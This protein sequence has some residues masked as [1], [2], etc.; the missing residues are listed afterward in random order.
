MRN[1]KVAVIMSLYRSDDP[2]MLKIAIDSILN[3]TFK[4]DLLVYQD[5]EVSKKLA[6]TIQY[7]VENNNLTLFINSI[8]KGLAVGLNCLINH[9][10]EQEYEYIARMDSDDIS[11]PE[12][13]KKQVNFLKLNTEVDVLGTSCQEFSSPFALSEKHLPKTHDE[14]LDFSITRC[15]FIH[16]TVMFRADVFKAGYRYP[17]DV[18]L[19]ED[20]AFWFLLLN[21]NIRFANM[22]EILLDYRLNETTIIRRKGLNKSINEVKLRTRNMISLKKITAKNVFLITARIGFHL[23]PSY[24]VKLAYKKIR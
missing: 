18:I 14:L 6:E 10:I 3:Q 8:N 21:N 13:I 16:P 1:S 15:P 7:Y 9:A 12:R 4:C 23:L 11:R 20:M 22:N 2:E 24:F 17:E 19:T 5:G